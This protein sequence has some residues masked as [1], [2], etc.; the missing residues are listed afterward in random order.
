LVEIQFTGATGKIC[1]ADY[2]D[3]AI[4]A[5]RIL[6]PS[7]IKAVNEQ[8]QDEHVEKLCRFLSDKNLIKSLNLR[9][10]KIG[11]KGAI[12][13]A[14]YIKEADDTLTSL[15][16]ERNEIGDAGGEALLKAMQ[17]N[18]RMECCKMAY[19]NPMRQKICSLI[20]RE[21]KANI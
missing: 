8:L 6:G 13:L 20:G 14:D 4:K 18:M 21:I 15:E 10:N 5:W 2:F 11:D 7:F 17:A 3:S 1:I 16:L 9:R 19:G 12:A